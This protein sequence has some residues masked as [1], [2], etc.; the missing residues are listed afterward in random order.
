LTGWIVLRT[1][2]DV[3][4]P[5]NTAKPQPTEREAKLAQALRANLRRRKTGGESKPSTEPKLKD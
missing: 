1:Q 2:W 5:N 4:E 3:A